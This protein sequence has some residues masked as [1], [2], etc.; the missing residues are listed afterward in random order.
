MADFAVITTLNEEPTIGQLVRSLRG[1]GLQVVVV[2]DCSADDTAGAALRA[3]A[4]VI[5]TVQRVGIG[6]AL[7]MG[8]REAL[9]RGATR[10]VQ[11]DAGGSH[12]PA[13]AMQLLGV[14]EL[15]AAD[16]VVGSR[17]VPGARYDARTGRLRPVLSRVAAL[18]CNVAT[19]ARFHDW[20]SGCRAFTAEAARALRL[21]YYTAAMHGWQIEV[22]ARANA[23][24]M[25]I[26][27]APITYTAGRS[28][29]NWRVAHEASNSLLHVFF[30]VGGRP[31]GLPIGCTGN[32]RLSQQQT[33]SLSFPTVREGEQG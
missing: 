25:R 28:S 1:H 20:T 26:V 8:W 17:F 31:R 30:H 21:H 5:E 14:L 10:L 6:P 19:G 9:R 3:G 32:K 12:D 11:L 24:G 23:D 33:G 29:F 15:A 18:A 4:V 7:M 16:V 27:E 22:L 13:E 2:D